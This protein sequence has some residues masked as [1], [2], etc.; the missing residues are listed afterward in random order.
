LVWKSPL[1]EGFSISPTV[2]FGWNIAGLTFTIPLTST[3]G[4]E[5]MKVMF[6]SDT[7]ALGLMEARPEPAWKVRLQVLRNKELL[8]PDYGAM[9][10]AAYLKS[11]GLDFKVFNVVADVHR[12]VELF[13]EPST[14][15]EEYSC[16]LISKPEAARRSREHLFESIAEYQPDV[17]LVT[18]SIYNLALYTRKLLGEIREASR[19]SHLVTGGIYSTLHA[20]DILSDGWVDIVVRGEGEVTTFDLLEA[21]RSGEGPSGIPGVSFVKDG[22][23]IHNPDR[24]KVGS[25]DHFPH[26]YTVSD[27]F[28]IKR[29]F[30]LLSRLNPLADYIP[31]TGFLTSR[32]CPEKCTFCLDPALNR[33]R[34]RF[35]SP[36]YVRNVLDYCSWRF[37][38]DSFFF[39][40]ATFTMHRK[41]L[42]QLLDL[43]EGLPY[44]YQI[45]TRA[46]YLDREVIGWLAASGFTHIAIGAESFN[47]KVLNDSAGKRLDVEQ[48]LKAS[49]QVKA[50]G[51]KPVLTFIV[52]LPGESRDSVWRTVRIL[53]EKGLET[54]TFFPLVVFRGTALYEV[55]RTRATESDLEAARLHPSSEEFLFLGDEFPT[56]DE[57]MGF[58]DEV[59]RAVGGRG[60]HG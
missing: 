20:Q 45:Q 53:E 22:T 37:E 6:V 11:R 25:L 29:R 17:V 18:L 19:D 48:T 38:A 5:Q 12:D 60:Q 40:D 1:P 47:Q 30:D 58:A 41:R 2:S 26:L 50:A 59:N 14:D 33:Q 42:R 28:A 56:R 52:G 7:A 46:D 27:E 9:H 24:D 8:A 10:V 13:T 15:P 21:L 23:V 44:S 57:L 34:V 39:G 51:M 16:S 43:L 35:H 55:L 4:K 3:L 31:G 36:R 54:A 49:A 32:G